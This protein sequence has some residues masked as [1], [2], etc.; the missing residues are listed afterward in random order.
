VSDALRSILLGTA[1]LGLAAA[2]AILLTWMRGPVRA[3]AAVLRAAARV[4]VVALC[5]QLAH[6]AEE[7][8]TGF[9]RRFPAQLG[10]APWPQGF[11]VAFNVF[12]LAVWAWSARALLARSRMA[13]AALWFL[14]IAGMANAVVHPLLSL[15]AGGYFPGLVTSP[16]VG[17]AGCVLARKL[18]E[19]TR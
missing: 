1:G 8:A 7:L 17:V 5:V 9:P 4:A 16:L 2:L 18:C 15:R 3:D 13:L 6:F 12:W 19:V 14:A 11:F 10:L